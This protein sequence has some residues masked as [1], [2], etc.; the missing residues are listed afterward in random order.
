MIDLDNYNIEKKHPIRNALKEHTMYYVP[1]ISGIYTWNA[2]ILLPQEALERCKYNGKILE[3]PPEIPKEYT[4]VYMV[5]DYSKMEVDMDYY[6]KTKHFIH[7]GRAYENLN[8]TKYAM[9]WYEKELELNVTTRCT[10][11]RY[12]ALYRMAALKLLNHNNASHDDFWKAYICN[13]FRKET[14]YYLARLA[15]SDEKY[16][17]CLLYTHAAL[18]VG[19]P[20]L[21]EWY[22]EHTIYNWAMEDQ[23][24]EC[25]YYVGHKERAKWYWNNILERTDLP[26]EQTR[27]RIEK[28]SRLL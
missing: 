28:N 12:Y 27:Q 1:I 10:P 5:Q 3:C 15:S 11:E 14:L 24:A 4:E 9:Q 7:L 16:A 17:T 2:P 22:V 6:D 23:H 20:S 13:P 25:L 21:E 8:E 19:E 26:N 18:I